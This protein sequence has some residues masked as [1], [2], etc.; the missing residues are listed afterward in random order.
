MAERPV[1]LPNRTG[2]RL[3]ETEM[4]EFQWHAGMAPSQK[5]RNVAELHNAA[6]KLGLTPLLETSSKSPRES[7]RRL[8]AFHLSIAVTED[9]NSTVESVFQGSKVFERGGPFTE[10]YELESRQAKLDERL[11]SSGKLT[12][13]EL[14]GQRYPLSPPTVFYDWLY[15]RALYPHREWL[16][17]LS[18]YRGFTDIEFNPARSINCQARS[19]ALFVALALRGY[20]ELAVGSFDELVE[21]EADMGI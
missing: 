19:C 21:I 5:K 6:A 3:L 17:R 12:A 11:Q 8:S 1:F 16:E 20:L 7:G 2:S 15:L 9:L 13:F 4:V 18:Y 10:L 14:L